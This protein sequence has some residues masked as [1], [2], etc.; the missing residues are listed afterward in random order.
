MAWPDK[1][2]L[3]FACLVVAFALL[4]LFLV[5]INTPPGTVTVQDLTHMGVWI[6]KAEV[7]V[8]LPVWLAARLF[9][10]V[11]GGPA[12]RKGQQNSN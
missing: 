3:G 2:G 9:D 1:V 7:F 12:R 11:I 5:T 8:A 10:F 6:I 4:G